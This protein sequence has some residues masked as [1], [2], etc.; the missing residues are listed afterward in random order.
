MTYEQLRDEVKMTIANKLADLLGEELL[1]E[2]RWSK[3]QRRHRP[4]RQN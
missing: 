1:P 4:Q 3:A 2:S